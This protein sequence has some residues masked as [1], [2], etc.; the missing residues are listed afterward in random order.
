MRRARVST[1][2]P[3]KFEAFTSTLARPVDW[4]VPEMIPEVGSMLRPV[5]NPVAEKEAAS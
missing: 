4:G 5:G 1:F 3:Y 2:E